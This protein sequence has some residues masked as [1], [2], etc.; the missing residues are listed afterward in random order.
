MTMVDD[1]RLIFPPDLSPDMPF[2]HPAGVAEREA[3]IDGMLR[4]AINPLDALGVEPLFDVD[5]LTRVAMCYVPPTYATLWRDR[6]LHSMKHDRHSELSMVIAWIQ[7]EITAASVGF[8]LSHD[9][10][11]YERLYRVAH[12]SV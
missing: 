5:R 2:E 12:L 4:K 11:A 7:H 10:S 9:R 6:F 3:W 1:A 8:H